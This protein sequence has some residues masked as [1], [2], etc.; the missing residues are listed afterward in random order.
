[1]ELSLLAAGKL[2]KD[3]ISIVTVAVVCA[4]TCAA[5]ASAD[6]VLPTSIVRAPRQALVDI[7][8]FYFTDEIADSTP[9]RKV[10]PP[11][12]IPSSVKLAFDRV[13][14]FIPQTGSLNGIALA[15]DNLASGQAIG[16]SSITN[17]SWTFP[18][19]TIPAPSQPLAANLAAYSIA[20]KLSWIAAN[21]KLGVSYVA[22][23]SQTT[24]LEFSYKGNHPEYLNGTELQLA[25]TV[26]G[27]PTGT[28]L[29]DIQLTYDV[30][31][32]MTGNTLTNIWSYS[33]NGGSS[34]IF[35]TNTVTGNTWETIN[36]SVAGLLL[37]NGETIA[38]SD[39]ITGAA[40]NNGSL[41]FDNLRVT[42]DLIPEPKSLG[43]AMLGLG[44]ACVLHILRQKLRRPS[45][46]GRAHR[47]SR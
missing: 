17:A 42:S 2:V 24:A 26:S 31:W 13:S 12:S 4:S 10:L 14:G 7:S 43:L 36:G 34:V 25:S 30:K 18:T 5:I 22:H 28:F 19:N 8:D 45:P 39:T 40:G 37:N 32:S 41:D 3:A 20:D 16:Y 11:L 38:F 15:L 23:P 44:N 6:W 27:L 29:T 1:M 47:W 35:Q 9:N 46:P 33:I 21:N